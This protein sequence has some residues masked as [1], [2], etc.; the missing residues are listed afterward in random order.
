MTIA[1]HGPFPLVHRRGPLLFHTHTHAHALA[2]TPW[3]GRHGGDV[4]HANTHARTHAHT[5]TLTRSH[6]HLGQGADGGDVAHAD[7]G[8]GRRLCGDEIYKKNKKNKKIK[9]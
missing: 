6:T 4:A 7:G 5:H 9:K 3:P 1:P 2:L 8:I